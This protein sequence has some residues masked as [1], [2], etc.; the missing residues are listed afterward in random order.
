MRRFFLILWAV[1]MFGFGPCQAAPSQLYNKTVSIGWTVQGMVRDP[2]GKE[3]GSNSSINYIVYV[4]SA[5]RVFEKAS[6]SIGNRT[7]SS[8]SEPGAN[9]TKNGEARGLQFQGNKMVINRGY[10]GGGGSGAMLAVVSFDPS[11]SSCTLNVTH[12][13]EGGG[14]IK[15]KSM[16]GIVRELLQLNV[17]STSCSIREGNPFADN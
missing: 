14:V 5:G 6:R 9:R 13:K 17:K 11:F 2:D 8:E 16:D 3:H 10:S 7:G 1:V 4:S 15:R 12:G